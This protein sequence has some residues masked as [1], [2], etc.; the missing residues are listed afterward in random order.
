MISPNLPVI[1]TIYCKYLLR[2]WIHRNKGEVSFSGIEDIPRGTPCLF[3]LKK[4][5]YRIILN[6]LHILYRNESLRYTIPVCSADDN[7]PLFPFKFYNKIIMP[8]PGRFIADYFQTINGRLPTQYE[9]DSLR[10]VVSPLYKADTNQFGQGLKTS[11]E[12]NFI[13]SV[14]AFYDTVKKY[15]LEKNFNLI[16]FLNDDR[17]FTSDIQDAAICSGALINSGY[18]SCGISVNEI[19]NISGSFNTVFSLSTVCDFYDIPESLI[20]TNEQTQNLIL[21]LFPD[22]YQ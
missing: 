3:V 2:P 10:N 6:L 12:T 15:T 20:P 17:Y 21:S 14:K 18:P 4:Y 7:K 1:E 8:S 5:D 16:L 9:I 13:P 22:F 11:W 19:K